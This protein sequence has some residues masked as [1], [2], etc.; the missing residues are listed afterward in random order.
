MMKWSSSRFFDSNII[1]ACLKYIYNVH[2]IYFSI[3]IFTK[4]MIHTEIILIFLILHILYLA[5]MY[6]QCCCFVAIM[7]VIFLNLL[8]A[9]SFRD[10]IAIRQN[11]R[12]I[13]FAVDSAQ[14]TRSLS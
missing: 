11:E 9:G 8:N 5:I 7:L 6:S 2:K 12:L 4:C 3:K 1:N 13:L 14:L 10:K